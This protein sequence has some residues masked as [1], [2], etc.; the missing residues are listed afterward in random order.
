MSKSRAT[1]FAKTAVRPLS[2]QPY[3]PAQIMHESSLRKSRHE[4]LDVFLGVF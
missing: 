3:A 4:E 1:E 2:T